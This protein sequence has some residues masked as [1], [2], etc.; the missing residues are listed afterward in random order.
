[1]DGVGWLPTK[2]VHRDGGL[3][4]GAVGPG[5]SLMAEIVAEFYGDVLGRYVR[6][7]LLDLGCGRA[8]LYAGYREHASAVTTSDWKAAPCVDVVADLTA[9][10]LPFDDASF[11]TVVL[12]DVLEHIPTPVPL[13]T[14]VRRVMRPGGVLLLNVPFLYGVHE[15]P[16]D[17]H[18]YTEFALR[19]MAD[20]AGFDV[21]ELRPLGGLPEVVGDLLGKGLTVLPVVGKVL[22]RGLQKLVWLL[23]RS[24]VGRAASRRTG[25]LTP[26]G[27][28][29]VAR[30]RG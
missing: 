27:Y 4:A 8:P 21:V 15:A 11:D 22:A 30:A 28:G 5:S 19:R 17:Y 1:M 18:R 9:V 25:P 3:R 10:P 14:D 12:S 6:G 16:H 13:L 24:K 29:L 20:E 23:H 7:E 26:S 2:Y